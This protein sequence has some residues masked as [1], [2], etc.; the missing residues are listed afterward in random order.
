MVNQR[1][2]PLLGLEIERQS[3]FAL[4]AWE[5]LNRAK[6]AS[7]LHRGDRVWYSIQALLVAV[8]NI[9]KILW[10]PKKSDE[11]RGRVLRQYFGIPDASVLASREFRN[12]LEHFDKR[13]V[14][15]LRAGHGQIV[16][17]GNLS[18][19]PEFLPPTICLRQFDP[20]TSTVYFRDDR[21]ELAPVIEAV[22]QLQQSLMQRGVTPSEEDSLAT[23]G[24]A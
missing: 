22:R 10:P 17:D 1:L 20:G 19:P 8:A 18:S 4:L 21:I 24:D 11:A 16:V 15:W 23:S 12:H 6:S 3:K 13:L 5:D 9:S 14:D 7:E 2:L